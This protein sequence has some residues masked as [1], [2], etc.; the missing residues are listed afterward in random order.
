M[1]KHRAPSITSLKLIGAPLSNW[2]R[3]I[4]RIAMP[5]AGLLALL[6]ATVFCG[7]VPPAM[8][9]WFTEHIVTQPVSLPNGVSVGVAPNATSNIPAEYLV[10]SNTSPTWLYLLAIEPPY[11]TTTG[12]QFTAPPQKLFSPGIPA[13]KVA[14]G[15]A[16]VWD[17]TSVNPPWTLGWKPVQ[18]YYPSDTLWLS[19]SGPYIEV[20]AS[21]FFQYHLLKIEARNQFDS[22]GR[23]P[24]DA[25]IP[26]PQ[27]VTLPIVYGGNPINVPL[28]ISYSLNTTYEAN[29]DIV[30]PLLNSGLC[31]P[32][33][34]VALFGLGLAYSMRASRKTAARRK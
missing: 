29:H 10:I 23:R 32:I 34:L 28:T 13:F 21:A 12:P 1:A 5:A 7:D 18:E 9:P 33:V 26:A 3:Y 27:T 15:Q 8:Q 25:Q 6:A 24:A 4:G 31:L 22:G 2:G 30:T 11:T 20:R 17:V 14:S 19:I 16:L